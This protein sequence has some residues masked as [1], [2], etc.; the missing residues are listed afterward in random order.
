MGEQADD[1]STEQPSEQPQEKLEKKPKGKKLLQAPS[2]SKAAAKPPASR[3]RG[4]RTP[5]TRARDPVSTIKPAESGETGGAASRSQQQSSSDALEQPVDSAGMAHCCIRAEKSTAIH[6]P[7]STS[8]IHAKG[9]KLCCLSL[10]K[11]L[12]LNVA[13]Y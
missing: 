10:K 11:K 9:A 3:G 8:C 4:R 5:T 7:P 13:G 1:G 12:A 2:R 6:V